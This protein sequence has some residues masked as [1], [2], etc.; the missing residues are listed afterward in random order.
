MINL[1]GTLYT[2]DNAQISPL[3]RG[4]HFGDAVFETMRVSAG[5]VLFWEDHYFRLMASMR[6]LRMEIPMDFTLEHLEEEILKTVKAQQEAPAYRVKFLVWRSWGGGYGPTEKGVE[7]TITVAALEHPFYVM[8]DSP[9]EVELFK[10]HFVNSGLLS[11]LKTNNKAL[12][13]LGS[14]FAEENGYQNCLLLNEHKMVA[15]ALN[16]NLFWV[17]GYKIKTPPLSDGCLKGVLRKQLLAILAQLPDYVVEEASISPFDL[18][19]ADELFLTNAILGIQ[20][21]T[22][23]RKKNFEVKVARELVGKLNARAR[24]G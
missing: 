13:V 4:F 12:H 22:K 18:Q 9:Y 3:N 17:Q 1:N 15:E 16:G 8:N 11:T 21:I 24:L 20:P 10:D 19:K 2:S 6:I 14:I 23:Y 5:K 7:Y